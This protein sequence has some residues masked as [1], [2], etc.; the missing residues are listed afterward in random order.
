MLNHPEEYVLNLICSLVVHVSD[1]FSGGV[2]HQVRDTGAS[3]HGNFYTRI[4]QLFKGVHWLLIFLFDQAG[5]Q[6]G[7]V[8]MS[9]H[10]GGW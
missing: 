2:P 1:N 3:G 8:G 10:V 9:Q 4:E 6:V 5:K 7:L